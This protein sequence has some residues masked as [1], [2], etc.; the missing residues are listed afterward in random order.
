MHD[1]RGSGH[2]VAMARSILGMELLKTGGVDDPNGPRLL[3]VLKT[4]LGKYP[5]PLS[6]EF[7]ECADNTGIAIL[8]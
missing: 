1:L 2:L 8:L 4:N 6:V 7:E 3:K 5:K